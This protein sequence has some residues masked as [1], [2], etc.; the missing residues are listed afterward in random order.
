MKNWGFN[1]WAQSPQGRK[2][3]REIAINRIKTQKLNGEPLSPAIGEKERNCLNELQKYCNY[4]IKRN[5]NIDGYYEG[6][7]ESQRSLVVG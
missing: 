5:F 7:R 2:K 1:S 6:E 4:E 3:H